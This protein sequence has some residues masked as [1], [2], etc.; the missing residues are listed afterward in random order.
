MHIKIDESIRKSYFCND[1]GIPSLSLPLA[2][3]LSSSG[4]FFLIKIEFYSIDPHFIRANAP[5]QCR[6]EAE[7]AH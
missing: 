4:N 1:V 6:A 5:Y 7:A 2:L 3:P